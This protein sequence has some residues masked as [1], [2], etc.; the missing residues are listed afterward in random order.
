MKRGKK[1]E[2]GDSKRKRGK[3][4]MAK[5]RAKTGGGSNYRMTSVMVEP[6]IYDE[7]IEI[8]PRSKSVGEALRE[9]MKEVVEE[10]RKEK[11]LSSPNYSPLGQCDNTIQ[12]KLDKYFPS[13]IIEWNS[14][15]DI[16]ESLNESERKK[17]TE[18]WLH[19]FRILELTNQS[20]NGSKVYPFLKV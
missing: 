8:I 2:L 18:I 19:D 14:F 11:N 15:K 16:V 1:P 13:H 4:K 10:K 5:K 9:Y 3:I 12:S 20:K 6:E 17:L 7:F